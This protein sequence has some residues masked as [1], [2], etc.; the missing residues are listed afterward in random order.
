M[1]SPFPGMDPYLE[2]R[3]IW[4]DLH[5]SLITYSRDALQ[6]RIRPRYHAR[7]G[8]RIYVIPSHRIIYPDISITWRRPEPAPALA[9]GVAVLAPDEPTIISVPPQEVRETFV[10]ILDLTQGGR[11]VTVIEVLSPA[12]KMP[13]EG[14]ELYLRKQ[15]ELLAGEV[16]LVEIDLLS[17]GEPTVAAPLS[18]LDPYRPWRYLIS[19]SRAGNREKFEVYFVGLRQRLPRV[20]IPLTEP[21]PDATLDLQAV[22]EQ[23][24]ERGAYEDLVDYGKEPEARLTEEDAAWADALLRE[25]KLR[26]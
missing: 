16:H 14:R 21:D 3:A 6:P 18:S 20:A 11:L 5:Q 12:N 23:C 9:G 4:P 22:F 2:S 10:E 1:P 24:Y 26:A 7:I 17:Q 19:V 8:E 15:E 13:G 25:K